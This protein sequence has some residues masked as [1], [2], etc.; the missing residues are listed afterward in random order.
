M[1]PKRTQE[2]LPPRRQNAARRAKAPRTDGEQHIASPKPGTP[3]KSANF[4]RWSSEPGMFPPTSSVDLPTTSSMPLFSPATESPAPKS[5][6]IALPPSPVHS[7]SAYKSEPATLRSPGLRPA[8]E[9]MVALAHPRHIPTTSTADSLPTS[10]STAPLAST[11]AISTAHDGITSPTIPSVDALR[12]S[13]ESALAEASFQLPQPHPSNSMGPVPTPAIYLGR[14]DISGSTAVNIKPDVP[15]LGP[16]PR[17]PGPLP[18]PTTPFVQSHWNQTIPH[19]SSAPQDGFHNHEFPVSNHQGQERP[20]IP[21]AFAGPYVP[22]PLPGTSQTGV[23]QRFA[24]FGQPT[25]G[26]YSM[27]NDPADSAAS[28]ASLSSSQHA[29]RRPRLEGIPTIFSYQQPVSSAPIV[30][31]VLLELPITADAKVLIR[32]LLLQVTPHLRCAATGIRCGV[33]CP[34]VGHRPPGNTF[35]PEAVQGKLVAATN[36]PS[37]L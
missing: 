2:P 10:T 25:P 35:V 1:P 27:G 5:L 23:G 26:S 3:S 28:S 15:S 20:P 31:L 18:H 19:L 4:T 34:S 9:A 37:T 14:P 17:H 11:A 33:T 36:V 13:V 30:P 12:A 22:S 8:I 16:Q 32:S 6:T 29:T 7:P 21:G 24:S